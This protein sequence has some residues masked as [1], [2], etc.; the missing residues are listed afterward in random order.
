MVLE[1]FVEVQGLHFWWVY[2]YKICHVKNPT[3]QAATAVQR[4]EKILDQLE[5]KL[6]ED[7]EKLGPAE[8]VRLWRDLQ[9]FIRPKLGRTELPGEPGEHQGERVIKVEV[10]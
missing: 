3:A 4:I 2:T 6:P 5:E 8:R 7:L 9:E 10:V 1:T